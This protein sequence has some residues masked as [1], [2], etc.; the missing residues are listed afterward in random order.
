MLPLYWLQ[1]GNTE[2][3][4]ADSNGNKGGGHEEGAMSQREVALLE[5]GAMGLAVAKQRKCID[6]QSG[7]MG[8]VK[9]T[10]HLQHFTMAM[11]AW[12]GVLGAM[13]VR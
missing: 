7:R 10:M 12:L 8:G 9:A 1:R 2:V 3:R 5:Q 6:L 13:E 4:C 11:E